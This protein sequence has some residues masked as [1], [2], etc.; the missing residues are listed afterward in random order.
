MKL[1]FLLGLFRTLFVG[2]ALLAGIITI[3]AVL[4]IAVLI[5]VFNR[6]RSRD[7]PPG[8]TISG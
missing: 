4:G 1:E 8:S 2:G 6:R 3:V 7:E 5:V